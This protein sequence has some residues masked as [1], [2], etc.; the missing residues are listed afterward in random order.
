LSP[1][2]Y[3]EPSIDASRFPGSFSELLGQSLSYEEWLASI[4]NLPTLDEIEEA[5]EVGHE[6]IAEVMEKLRHVVSFA[7]TPATKK[8]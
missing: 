2:A 6:L 3:L 4:T 8:P 7:V 5:A 1:K